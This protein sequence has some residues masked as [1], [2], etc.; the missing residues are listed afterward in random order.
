[1]SM[2]RDDYADYVTEHNG[3]FRLTEH[4][5]GREITG[6]PAFENHEDAIS[7]VMIA[8]GAYRAGQWKK[9]QDMREVL[10]LRHGS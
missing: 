6:G 2:T 7:A 4:V 3:K 8:F 9:Q 10:G 5:P 1:M